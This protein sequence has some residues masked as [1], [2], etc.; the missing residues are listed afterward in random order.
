MRV[1]LFKKKKIPPPSLG[2]W[3]LE[4]EPL[5]STLC[6]FK[7]VPLKQLTGA[8]GL[9]GTLGNALEGGVRMK[10]VEIFR[11]IYL[12]VHKNLPF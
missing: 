12:S 7:G 1:F 11:E 2:S 4:P 8:E 9:S 5:G 10:V 3:V 6:P